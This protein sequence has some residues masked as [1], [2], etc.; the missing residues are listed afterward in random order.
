MAQTFLPPAF[1][2]DFDRSPARDQLYADWHN[3]MNSLAG[4]GAT[5]FPAAF[6]SIDPPAGSNPR[7]ASPEWTGLPR[8]IKRIVGPSVATAAKLVDEPRPVGAMDPVDLRAYDPFRDSAGKPF[9]G[10]LYRSQDEYLEWS[11]K[12]DADGVI[13]EVVFTCEGPEYWDRIATDEKLLLGLYR[14]ICEDNSVA[15]DDLRFDRDLTWLNPYSG[16]NAAERFPKGSY[17]RYNRWNAAHAVHLTHP[18]NTLGAEIYLALLA[19]RPYG[20]PVPV[21]SDP[22][23]VCCAAYG[24]INRM[25]DPTIGSGVNTQVIQLKRRVALRNPIGLYIRGIQPNI[26]TLADGTPFQE[27]EG[28][29]TVL[30]PEPKDVSDMILRAKF[31][32]PDGVTVSGKQLRV[33]DLSLHGEAVVTG[34]QLADV[35]TM[36]LYA[37]SIPGAPAQDPVACVFAPCRD[38]THPDFIQAIPFGQTCPAGGV[39]PQMT[40]LLT[41][42]DTHF[43]TH[44]E[45]L[46]P[47]NANDGSRRYS[48]TPNFTR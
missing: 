8:T 6:S 19:T 14:E 36:T 17:N 27:Q 22:D 25:S 28:C 26:F 5:D 41:A 2:K 44:W 23:L 21:T 48:R 45:Q 38:A 12:R 34:G 40:S 16:G 35:V 32:V 46:F 7:Q 4:S 43:K 13:S 11:V 15:L 37:L 9:Q 24:G 10:P 31:R 29:W 33:G 18:A 42:R 30:R 20:N 39:S 47:A 1:L 3:E